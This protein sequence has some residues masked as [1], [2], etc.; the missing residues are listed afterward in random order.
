MSTNLSKQRREKLLSNIKIMREKL[1]GNK[2]LVESLAEMENELKE[3]RYGLIWEEHEER[4]DEEIKT[5]IP[6]FVE[7]KGLEIKSEANS[8]IN[9]LIEGD[10]LHSLYLLEKTNDSKI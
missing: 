7:E 9:F 1:E 6:V 5:Q 10:N 2:D 4:V 8:P 3:K